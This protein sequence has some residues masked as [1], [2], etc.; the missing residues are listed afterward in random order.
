MYEESFAGID[1][2]FVVLYEY[3]CTKTRNY[4]RGSMGHAAN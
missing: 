3:R 4:P 1:S 2:N